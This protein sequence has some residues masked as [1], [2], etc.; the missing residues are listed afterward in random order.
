MMKSLEGTR[1]QKSQ[2]ATTSAA[3]A[4]ISLG[5]CRISV[6]LLAVHSIPTLL[7]LIPASCAPISY[8]WPHL[9]LEPSDPTDECHLKPLR[10]VWQYLASGRAFPGSD[11]A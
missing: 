11:T 5:Y 4:F 8:Q 6:P 2:I 10:L 3:I 9:Y 7:V 1:F